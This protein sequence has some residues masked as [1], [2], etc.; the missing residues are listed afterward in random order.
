MAE[1]ISLNRLLPGEKHPPANVMRKSWATLIAAQVSITELAAVLRTG[2]SAVGGDSVQ[3]SHQ[4]EMAELDLLSARDTLE[5]A[6]WEANLTIPQGDVRNPEQAVGSAPKPNAPPAGSMVPADA[7]HPAG[8]N[9]DRQRPR[10]APARGQGELFPLQHADAWPAR[11]TWPATGADGFLEYVDPVE[12]RWS[13]PR[14]RR[15]RGAG[16]DPGGCGQSG[17]TSL[18]C[19]PLVP[20]VTV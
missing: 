20:C 10:R 1:E 19:G 15:V 11:M 3:I 18:A 12:S 4:L 17:V 2:R 16:R 13:G 7:E 6:C 9:A 8:R 14:R 5:K